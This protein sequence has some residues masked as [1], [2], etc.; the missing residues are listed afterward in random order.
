[1]NE[2]SLKNRSLKDNAAVQFLAR[3][4]LLI[5]LIIVIAVFTAIVPNFLTPKN[6]FTILKTTGYVALLGFSCMIIMR[7]GEMT[8]SIGAQ[9]T[10]A[11]AICGKLLDSVS[12]HN[13]YLAALAGIAGSTLLLMLIAYFVIVWKV[14]SFIAT[15]GLSTIMSAIVILLTGNKQMLSSKWPES[16]TMFK[17]QTVFGIPL[18]IVAAFAILLIL[19]IVNART[20]LGRYLFCVGANATATEQ[21][22]INVR[23]IKY[24]AFILSGVVAGIA[25]C[26]QASN[27]G[28]VPHSLGGDYLMTTI[29]AA[30][31]SATFIKPGDYNV[32]GVVVGSFILIIIKNAVSNLGAKIYVIDLITAVILL[33]GIGIIAL[34]RK[35]GLI[36][37][38]FT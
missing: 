33:I 27:L 17:T 18:M 12:F 9:A 38:T 25:G 3:Y 19:G 1:M 4:F 5:T 22:G 29:C 30:T 16:F 24:I 14:P 26:L 37:I 35:E 8:F 28:Q 31:L 23:K 34:V 2:N 36:K 11:A 7:I 13:Y 6:I 21:S 32:P 20:K 10:L 15:L